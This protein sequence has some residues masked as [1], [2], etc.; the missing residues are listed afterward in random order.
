MVLANRTSEQAPA[1]H[2][3]VLAAADRLLLNAKPAVAKKVAAAGGM[4]A[5]QHVAH[6][7]AWLATTIEAMRQLNAWAQRLAAEG[8]LGEIE[9]LI[10]DIGI[11]EYAAQIVGGIAMSQLESI[12][13]SAL[14][15]S[16]LD[17][18]RFEDAAA[19]A[20]TGGASDASKAQLAALIAANP[21]A[22]TFG[23]SGLDETHASI[24]GEMNRFCRAEVLPHAHQWHL[25]NAYIPLETIAKLAELGVFGVSNYR[26]ATS[27]SARSAPGRRLPAN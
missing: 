27:A 21:E 7:F 8:K 22:L 5:A 16:T 24:Q 17:A 11:G 19:S 25:Q 13:L 3:D 26:A 1:L 10:L 20:I 2:G 12:R 6:G 18:R 15:I 23:D 14:G 9:Q 4:D